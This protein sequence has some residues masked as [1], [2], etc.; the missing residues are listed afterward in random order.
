MNN[1]PNHNTQAYLARLERR[2][3]VE[4]ALEK[5]R[6]R[7]IAMRHS[8]E[9]AAC[10][11]EIYQQLRA[12]NLITDAE[13]F[14]ISIWDEA[15][16]TS[17]MWLNDPDGN[18]DKKARLVSWDDLP[19]AVEVFNKWQSIPVDERKQHIFRNTW[20]GKDASDI[21]EFLLSQPGFKDDIWIRQLKRQ[22]PDRILVYDAFYA[23]GNLA[24]SSLREIDEE[25]QEV[26][27]RFAAVFELSYTRFLDLKQAEAQAQK[28][29][30]EAALERVRASTIAMNASEDLADMASVMFENLLSLYDFE[31]MFTRCVIVI[32]HEAQNVNHVWSTNF[33]GKSL[34][35]SRILPLQEHPVQ[36]NI[37]N[38][39]KADRAGFVSTGFDQEGAKQ[40]TSYLAQLPGFKDDKELLKILHLLEVAPEQLPPRF[41]LQMAF[42]THGRVGLITNQDLDSEQIDILKRFASVFQQAY[43]R[44]L[45]LQKSEA[46]ARET[47][48]QA[49][50]DRVRVEIASMR[51]TEDLQR[52]TPLIW[53]ALNKLDVPFSRCGVF[54]MD[55]ETEMIH[56]FV[57][58]PTGE[59]LAAL[60][61]PYDSDPATIQSVDAWRH[62]RVFTDQWD[63]QR[64]LQW[65]QMML[66]EGLVDS[67]AEIPDY[68][69][70]PK[71]TALH[72][73]PFSQ[74]MLYVGNAD[75]LSDE[76]IRLVQTVADAFSVAYARYEDFQAL[77]SKNAE[78]ATTLNYLEATQAQLIQSEKMASLGQLTAG[79]AH[80]IKNPLNFVN[81][82]AFLNSGLL[83]E[84]ETHLDA[85]NADIREIFETLKLNE[86]R[87]NEH[88][89]RADRIVNS[90]MR[91]A[92]GISGE[93]ERVVFNTFVE[94]YVNLAIH[95]MQA[96]QMDFHLDIER[97]YAE[98]AGEVALMPQEFGQVLVNM[99]NNAFDAMLARKE[100]LA[101]HGDN[102]Y[103]PLLK[104]RTEADQ[105]TVNLH[106]S[107]NG[108]GMPPH[109]RQKIFEPFFTTKSAGSGT[110]LGLS[111]S[112]DIITK[113]HAGR[114]AL[115]S[116]LNA[117]TTFIITLPR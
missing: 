27:K 81:N 101:S 106:I 24:V 94:E 37:Y 60:K 62:K 65:T 109:I 18:I 7:F 2:I 63:Q 85:N 100:D 3:A 61:V 90:M 113:G 20:E 116:E 96:R 35:S 84:L 19:P 112:Y 73:V 95:G 115:E 66:E 83:S 117:G 38:A 53:Q 8:D 111:L 105:Q 32:T 55:D 13:R 103:K 17:K 15:Q 44:F 70:P 6:N 11:N 64:F 5:V 56:S 10:A 29:Q 45:D 97:E 79:I 51:T 41:Y 88:G 69:D 104:I 12:L 9:L 68:A 48:Q 47:R 39:W 31:F 82:F 78:L 57:T 67:A 114:I 54:I 107:D 80:E 91:H 1:Q 33:A 108:G 89:K 93:R 4:E 99:F 14:H 92:N 52:V 40:Y 77:E 28:A 71:M 23:H 58:T 49:I 87:I 46:L 59:H 42:F 26:L 21:L 16:R 43:T 74:G 34:I 110:G 50:L 98:N 76:Q 30:I 25:T 36:A 22:R 75:P 86:S 102:A 72:F